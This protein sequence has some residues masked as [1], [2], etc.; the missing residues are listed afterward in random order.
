MKEPLRYGL[1]L[2]L[3]CFL[4]ASLLALVN[5]LTTPKI[6]AQEILK[7]E[8]GLKEISP[9]GIFF[10]PLRSNNETAYYK[11]FDINKVLIGVVFKARAL[12]YSSMIDTLAGMTV[13][14]KIT[15]IKVLNQNETP[16]LGSRISEPDFTGQFKGK[17][18]PDLKDIQAITGA[19]ISSKAVIDSVKSKASKIMELIKNER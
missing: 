5:F 3:I 17:F 7:Q 4:A 16:G 1:I 6:M 19:T 18:I 2:G 11:V 10:E 8:N 14:G 15:A 12:G 9:E 13:E